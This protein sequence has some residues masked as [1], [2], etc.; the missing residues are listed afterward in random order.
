MLAALTNFLFGFLKHAL[1]GDG[2]NRRFAVHGE[3]HAHSCP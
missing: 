2:Y 3:Q 1:E